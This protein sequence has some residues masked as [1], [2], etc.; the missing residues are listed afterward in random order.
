[1]DKHETTYE[2]KWKRLKQLI[3]HLNGKIRVAGHYY[4]IN[5]LVRS[6]KLLHAHSRFRE[7]TKLGIILFTFIYRNTN[8]GKQKTPHFWMSFSWSC[9]LGCILIWLFSTF[10][11]RSIFITWNLTQS[12]IK[13]N[14]RV[15]FSG[16]NDFMF[17][18]V[19]AANL[20]LNFLFHDSVEKT[21]IYIDK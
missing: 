21:L 8:K 19:S 12:L 16:I 11:N 14:V 17:N 7:Q 6:F 10:N 9:I 4:S 2:V 13:W 20:F 15:F 3:P 1:M 18:S 5:P